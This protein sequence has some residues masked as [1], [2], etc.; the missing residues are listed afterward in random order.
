MWGG[1]WCG[2]VHWGVYKCVD[3]RGT[4]CKWHMRET[5]TP[6]CL[7]SKATCALGSLQRRAR[8]LDSV[9]SEMKAGWIWAQQLTTK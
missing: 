6:T 4:S 2:L 7:H 8:P 5:S 9:Y 1:V 3:L